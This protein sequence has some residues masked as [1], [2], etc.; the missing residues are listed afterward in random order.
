[1]AAGD[2]GAGGPAFKTTAPA[3]HPRLDGTEGV[4][5]VAQAVLEVK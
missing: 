5:G 3:S 1:V 2:A 4:V